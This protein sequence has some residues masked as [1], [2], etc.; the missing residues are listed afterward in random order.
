MTSW[1]TTCLHI[2]FV[3]DRIEPPYAIVEWTE[4]ATFSEI[5]QEHFPTPPKEGTM[6]VVHFLP[7]KQKSTDNSKRPNQ[8]LATSIK[9]GSANEDVRYELQISSTFDCDSKPFGHIR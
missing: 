6:W 4:T 3:V 5:R 7:N 2:F 9:P 1:L 8:D